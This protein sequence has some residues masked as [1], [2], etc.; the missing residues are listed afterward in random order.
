MELGQ[1]VVVHNGFAVIIGEKYRLE[2]HL[3][4]EGD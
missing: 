3:N 2:K 1:L 4:K